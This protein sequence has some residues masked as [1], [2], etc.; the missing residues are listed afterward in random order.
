MSYYSAGS[1][2]SITAGNSYSCSCGQA[3]A[4]PT[5]FNVTISDT[6]ITVTQSGSVSNTDMLMAIRQLVVF[7]HTSF[8]PQASYSSNIS[9]TINDGV[10]TSTPVETIVYVQY[11]NTGPIILINNQVNYTYIYHMHVHDHVVHPIVTIFQN[12]SGEVFISDGVTNIPLVPNVSVLDDVGVVSRVIV[13]LTNPVHIEDE[14]ITVGI[15]NYF[16][17]QIVRDKGYVKLT[18]MGINKL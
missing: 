6:S 10:F 3:P 1:L 18:Y 14:N 12:A 13:S 9:V 7:E 8:T 4:S 17:I 2:Y 11:D 5:D 15:Q 16:N